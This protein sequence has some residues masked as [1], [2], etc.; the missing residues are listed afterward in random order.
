MRKVFILFNIMC[1]L[2]LCACTGPPTQHGDFGPELEEESFLDRRP[3]K[4]D[5]ISI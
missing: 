2:M 3:C 4:P 5:P 1:L